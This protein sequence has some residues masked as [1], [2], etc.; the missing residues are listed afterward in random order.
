M[1]KEEYV[2]ILVLLIILF[3]Q[4]G[5]GLESFGTAKAA[6]QQSSDA[7]KNIAETSECGLFILCLPALVLE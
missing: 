7:T 6:T 5:D 3:L 4:S 2:D 1:G